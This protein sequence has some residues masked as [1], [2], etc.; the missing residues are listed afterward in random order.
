MN[1][2]APRWLL[3][4]GLDGS[5]RLFR[6]FLPHLRDADAVVVGYPDESGWGFGDH[7]THAAKAIGDARRCIVV[8]ESFSGPIAL[9]LAQRDARVDGIVL[10]ASFVQRPNPLLSLLPLLPLAFVRR[11]ATARVLLRA[12]CLGFDAPEECIRELAGIV[13][14]LPVDLLRARLSLLRDLDLRDG[15]K[16]TTVPVLHLRAGKDRLVRAMLSDDAPPAGFREVV[17]DGPHFLLQARAQAC[18]QVV[19]EWSRHE[20]RER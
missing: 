8:A 3:L 1:G 13:R 5:G 2:G 9:H 19:E 15:L 20:V 6:W 10:V 11:L 14:A 17:V 7:A 18:W 4:P 12:F 16:R